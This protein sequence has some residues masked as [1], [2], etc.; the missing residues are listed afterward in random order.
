MTKDPNQ[1]NLPHGSQ[2]SPPAPS[3][4]RWGLPRRNFIGEEIGDVRIKE[5]LSQ[6]RKGLILLGTQESVDRPA[7][8]KLLPTGR[9]DV[10]E[11]RKLLREASTLSKLRHANITTL[12]NFGLYEKRYPYLVQEYIPGE[13]LQE[14]VEREE[15]LDPA[16]ALGIVQQMVHALEEAHRLSI[17]HQQLSPRNV[18][19]ESLAGSNQELAKLM[20]FGQTRWK[21]SELDDREEQ[22]ERALYMTPEEVLGGTYTPQSEF[23]VCGVILYRLLTGVAPY[24]G[25]TPETLWDEIV[26]RRPAPV[27]H[28]MPRLAIYASLQPLLEHLMARKASAR[29]PNA[30][31]ARLEIGHCLSEVEALQKKLGERKASSFPVLHTIERMPA[32]PRSAIPSSL[33]D[34]RARSLTPLDP[35]TLQLAEPEEPIIASPSRTEVPREPPI[36]PHPELPPRET[37]NTPPMPRRA[38]GSSGSQRR[39]NIQEIENLQWSVPQPHLLEDALNQPYMLVAILKRSGRIPKDLFSGSSLYL[40]TTFMGGLHC[41]VLRMPDRPL[42]QWLQQVHHKARG[43]DLSLG[44]SFGRRLDPQRR[45]PEIYTTRMALRAVHQASQGDIIA[46][47]HAVDALSLGK[48]FEDVGARAAGQYTSFLRFHRAGE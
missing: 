10:E 47:R 37:K 35:R 11:A 17:L 40:Y 4:S 29:P 32:I 8:V 14:L 5:V 23:Y 22:Y 13:T 7:V 12:Y 36:R 42:P 34:A 21:S 38:Q 28:Y 24:S 3:P 20:N 46:A 27:A 48:H 41:V 44:L 1:S 18:L 15:Q 9:H 30:R 16:R 25:E 31:A 43:A 2:T 45:K 33:N 6:T 19:L 26:S 39:Q